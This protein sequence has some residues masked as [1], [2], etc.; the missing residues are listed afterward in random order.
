MIAGR[1]FTPR[2]PFEPEGSQTQREVSAKPNREQSQ[3]P[4]HQRVLGNQQ[5]IIPHKLP[6]KG[7]PVSCE[8][9]QEDQH[10]AQGGP[11]RAM[12]MSLMFVHAALSFVL[13]AGMCLNKLAIILK[14]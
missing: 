13:I 8:N 7:R 10:H 9:N 4:G 6:P 5:F 2:Q 14:S 11:K 1:V 3:L 12:E